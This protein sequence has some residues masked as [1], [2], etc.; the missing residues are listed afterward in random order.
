MD[1]KDIPAEAI[2]GQ[3]VPVT[4]V[5]DNP[6]P[7]IPPNYKYEEIAK[8]S[9]S[10]IAHET[11][12]V[13]E[14]KPVEP[15]VEEKSLDEIGKKIAK[16]AAN[17]VLEKQKADAEAAEEARKA[18]EVTPPTE[19]E[20]IYTEWAEKFN[21]EKS[22]PPTYLEAMEFVEE[23]AIAKI[24]ERQQTQRVE[25]AKRAEDA[26]K[27]QDE[28]TKRIN[29]FVDD[30]LAELYRG[31]KLTKIQDPNN[32][33]D[34]GVL[35]RKSLFTK[36]AEVNNDRRA[37]GLPDIISAT[38]IAQGIDETGKPYWTK[39]N[40]QPAGADAPVMGS[41]SSTTPPDDGQQYTNADLKKPWSF[42]K[43][44]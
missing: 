41:R 31:N 37:K 38:R 12:P 10:E 8:E 11:P 14:E 19:K 27:A 21:Q 42:W 23:Q 17:A 33:S 24:E 20:R 39:P 22:R 35:E 4:P 28:E 34:Q 2:G 25:E 44:R 43:V 30:E 40:A 26:Q 32:P 5:T 18:A 6:P 16:D 13:V 3:E 9:M 36:W 7:I 1:P 15:V 29:T